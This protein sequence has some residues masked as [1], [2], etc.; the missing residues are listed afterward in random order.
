VTG[1]RGLVTSPLTVGRAVCVLPVI[2]GRVSRC[3]L[4]SRKSRFTLWGLKDPKNS[5]LETAELSAQRSPAQGHRC[6]LLFAETTHRAGDEL[7]GATLASQPQA[8]PSPVGSARP[9]VQKSLAFFESQKDPTPAFSRRL[10]AGEE[11]E[12]LLR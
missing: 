9:R 6:H 10:G 1:S 2:S 8:P 11:T 3:A 12:F 7:R 5:W 4:S